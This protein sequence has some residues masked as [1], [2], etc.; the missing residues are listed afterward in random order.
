MKLFALA[1][2]TAVN[3]SPWPIRVMTPAPGIINEQGGYWADQPTHPQA[4]QINKQVHRPYVQKPQCCEGYTWTSPSGDKLWMRKSGEHQSR[5]YYTATDNGVDYFLYYATI[6]PFAPPYGQDGYW[7][8]S[9][10]PPTYAPTDIVTKSKEI[11]GMRYCPQDYQSKPFEADHHFECGQ[12]PPQRQDPQPKPC[13]DTYKW[14]TPANNS[15]WMRKNGTHDGQPIYEGKDKTTGVT[16]TIWFEFYQP[17]SSSGSGAWFVSDGGFQA[18]DGTHRQSATIQINNQSNVCPGDDRAAFW[19]FYRAMS[20][21]QFVAQTCEET[22]DTSTLTNIVSGS[23]VSHEQCNIAQVMRQLVDKQMNAFVKMIEENDPNPSRTDKKGNVLEPWM[24]RTDFERAAT[25]WQEMVSRSSEI[26]PLTGDNKTKCGFNGTFPDKKPFGLIA[27]CN[28]M[29]ADIKPLE[30][31]THQESM[32]AVLEEF[33]KL[34]DQNFSDAIPSYDDQGCQ[35]HR[36]RMFDAIS[37]FEPFVDRKLD[38]LP[39]KYRRF[40]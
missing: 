6:S 23:S 34:F 15:V 3:A 33:L 26:H 19:D 40:V 30:L 4:P 37:L 10:K 27:N 14:T 5:P 7:Y 9:E 28:D 39:E 18:Y 1:A 29:C 13:C 38:G 24:I 11:L 25:A 17:G 20:C 22:T 12:G 36:D 16:K 2:A 31:G 21:E 32:A 8:L 35:D